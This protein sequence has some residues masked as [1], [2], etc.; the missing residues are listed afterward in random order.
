MKIYLYTAYDITGDDG[1][2]HKFLVKTDNYVS[3]EPNAEKTLESLLDI[4]NEKLGAM[5]RKL[6]TY[7]NK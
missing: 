2:E 6:K 1:V 7:A 4:H 5:E 3:T